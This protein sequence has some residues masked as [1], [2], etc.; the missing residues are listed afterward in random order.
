M[1]FFDPKKRKTQK[2]KKVKSKSPIKKTGDV[3]KPAQNTSSI[4]KA[5]QRRIQK[6]RTRNTKSLSL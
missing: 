5:L 1:E 6:G 4:S 2:V 3:K